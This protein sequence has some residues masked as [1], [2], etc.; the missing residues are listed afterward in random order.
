MVI[1]AKAMEMTGLREKRIPRSV[2]E[3]LQPFKDAHE[4]SYW[5]RSGVAECIDAGIVVGKNGHIL[6]P[7]AHITRAEAAVIMQRLLEQSGFIR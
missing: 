6:A 4:V 7:G 2:E 5:A 1:M 3:T